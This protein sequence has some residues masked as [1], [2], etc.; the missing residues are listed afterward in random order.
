[1]NPKLLI[2]RLN[3]WINVSMP[4]K[5]FMAGQARA[6]SAKHTYFSILGRRSL[7]LLTL[8]MS[9]EANKM[10][11]NCVGRYARVKGKERE[12]KIKTF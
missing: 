5:H 6:K 11:C 3:F 1:M 12:G 7:F 9:S 2:S 4:L 10:C 8:P